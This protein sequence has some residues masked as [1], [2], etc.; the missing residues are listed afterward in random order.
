MR[1]IG[2][3]AGNEKSRL[4]DTSWPYLLVSASQRPTKTFLLGQGH[5]SIVG[6][7]LLP[8]CRKRIKVDTMDDAR[9]ITIRQCHK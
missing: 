4:F 2:I 9:L 8:K 5:A 3:F 6:K 7:Y 1:G